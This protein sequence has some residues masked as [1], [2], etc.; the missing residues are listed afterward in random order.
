MNG[1]TAQS[2]SPVSAA[3]SPA[4]PLKP[5]YALARMQAQSL[6]VVMSY[7]L[8]GLTFLE[9][10]IGK[11]M[12][13]IDDLSTSLDGG[14]PLEACADFCQDALQDY[15]DE[16]VKLTR[17]GTAFATNGEELPGNG[18]AETGEPQKRRHDA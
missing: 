14:D 11:D 15:A 18:A 12:K 10:R 17:L 2:K 16:M 1:A 7:H 8:E 3:S 9:R 6:R 13:L 4:D 5:A